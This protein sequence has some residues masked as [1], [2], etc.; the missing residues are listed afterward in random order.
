MGPYMTRLHALMEALL[1]TFKRLE[2]FSSKKRY[3]HILVILNSII[4]Y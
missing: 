3:F 2:N 1:M 4:I